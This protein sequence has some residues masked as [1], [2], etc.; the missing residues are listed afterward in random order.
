MNFLKAEIERK[1]K[2]K[3]EREAKLLSEKRK[4]EEDGVRSEDPN[5]NQQK[6]FIRR[7]DL[8]KLREKEYFEAL[9]QKKATEGK[10]RK[11]GRTTA[12]TAGNCR[13]DTISHSFA[14]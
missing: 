11:V 14:N 4:R 3:E 12:A 5:D 13:R 9:E 1:R 2:E 8:E 6:K 7:G 10:R